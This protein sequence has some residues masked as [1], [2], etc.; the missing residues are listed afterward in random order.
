MGHQMMEFLQVR[1]FPGLLCEYA[2]DDTGWCIRVCIEKIK[3]LII[4]EGMLDILI[5]I[6]GETSKIVAEVEHHGLYLDRQHLEVMKVVYQKKVDKLRAEIF[7]LAGEEF[8]LNHAESASKIL[9]GKLEIDAYGLKRNKSGWPSTAEKWLSG[10]SDRHPII[11]KILEYRGAAKI[12]GTYLKPLTSQWMT[13]FNRVHASFMQMGTVTGRYAV[14]Q[15]GLQQLPGYPHD[16]VRKA[17]AAKPGYVLIQADWSQI[18]LR[19]MAWLSACQNML[20]AFVGDNLVDLH[21]QTQDST[22]CSTRTEAKV[23]NFGLAYL[24][25]VPTLMREL[26]GVPQETAQR[27]WDLYYEKYAEL[28]AFYQLIFDEVKEFGYVKNFTGRRRRFHPDAVKRM[29]WADENHREAVN[30]PVQGGAGELL[31]ISCIRMREELEELREKDPRWNEFKI[32]LF[33]HDEIVAE[34]P[35]AL[36]H[37]GAAFMK[38]HMEE[39]IVLP[40]HLWGV[41]HDLI[42]EADICICPYWSVSKLDPDEQLVVLRHEQELKEDKVRFYLHDK[43]PDAQKSVDTAIGWGLDRK[44]IT[45]RNISLST[46]KSI[47]KAMAKEAA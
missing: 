44:V 29:E 9:F 2:K 3:P 32:V 35:E 46:Y 38:R 5:K 27:Y 36:A 15:P 30:F 12:L 10:I 37:E 6:E 4:K 1:Q 19:L 16:G 23:I 8:N 24:M 17:V 45:D 43:Y 40:T 47:S 20:A 33:V 39:S 28:N 14:K 34:C 11:K 21:Q 22:G 42:L 25:Q 13:E 26:G 31:K 18:E 7:E 41:K